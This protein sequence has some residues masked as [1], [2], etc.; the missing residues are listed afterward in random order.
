MPDIAIHLTAEESRRLQQA[1]AS[2]GTTP[3]QLVAD[4]IR[5]RYA[6]ASRIGQVIPLHKPTPRGESR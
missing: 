4:E 5:R 1:A 3:E 6:L 2:L